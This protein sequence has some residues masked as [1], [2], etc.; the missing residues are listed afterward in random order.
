MKTILEKERRRDWR[1]AELVHYGMTLRAVIGLAEAQRYLLSRYV[2]PHVVHRALN[3]VGPRPSIP[4]RIARK[5]GHSLLV[6]PVRS[7]PP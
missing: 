2:P 3:A 6:K 7:G 4:T 5:F 1:M